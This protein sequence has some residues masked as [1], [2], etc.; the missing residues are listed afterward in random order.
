MGSQQYYGPPSI[1][2]ALAFAAWA[3]IVAALLGVAA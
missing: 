3:V 2:G 1:R